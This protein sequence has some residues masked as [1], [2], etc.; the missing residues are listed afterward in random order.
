M[1]LTD[2]ERAILEGKQGEAMRKALESIVLYGQ[3][4]GAQRLAPIEGGVHLVTSFGIPLLKPVFSL[5]DELIA[6]G[7]K[8][9]K[10][11][12]VDPRPM[13]FK[14]VPA[15]IIEKFIFKKI[16]YGKQAQYE[17]QLRKVGLKDDK[18]FTCTCYMEEVGN[19]PRKGQII[20]W[21][22]SSAVVYANS[23]L[24]ARSNRNSGVLELLCGITGRA[25]V[26]GLLTDEG[27]KADWLIEIK[28]KSLPEAQILGS[29]IG[30]K[31]MEEVPFI[32]G[33]DAF[34]GN[35]LNQRARDY[36]KDMGAAAA[37]NGAVGLYHV[38]GL[39][40]EA[41]EASLGLLKQGYR[42]YVID[43]AEL[44]KVCDGYPLMWKNPSAKPKIC[45]IGC[46]HLSLRQIYEWLERFESEMRFSENKKLAITTIMTAAPAVVD[47]FRKDEKAY[48]QLTGIGAHLTSICPLMYMNNPL[49]SRKAV[50]TNSN[51]LRTYTTA[52]YFT[53]GEIMNIAAKG[54][55][56]G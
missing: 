5:M 4:F 39:T 24:G 19:I 17:E 26:F 8:T 12:T 7:L 11:F 40:P 38:E 53:D 13:D 18:S 27:R 3:I 37:S 44:T 16:M 34:L 29:A 15:N 1:H 48:S 31:V 33:L 52:R 43:A 36:L 55:I 45:F 20:A 2:E 50:I 47:A 28:T 56:N 6:A 21:A 10:P 35:E 49:C 30:M 23:V 9:V 32:S 41:V 22:E 42:S 46:P 51:K 25:P 14:N 54:V